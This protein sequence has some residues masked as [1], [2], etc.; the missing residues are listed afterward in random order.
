MISYKLIGPRK[1]NKTKNKQ[2]I[3]NKKKLFV[4]KNNII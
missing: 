3:A 4:Y 2:Y 1:K